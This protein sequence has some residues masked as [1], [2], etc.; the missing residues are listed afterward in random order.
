MGGFQKFLGFLCDR[1]PGLDSE[2][3]QR[4]CLDF[5]VG[6]ANDVIYAP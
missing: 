4:N 1:S 6:K 2:L 3:D 5:T